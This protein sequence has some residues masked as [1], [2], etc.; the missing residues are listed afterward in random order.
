MKNY[1]EA[2]LDFFR[3]L[4]NSSKKNK[5][6]IINMDDPK[7][8][9]VASII[10]DTVKVIKIGSNAKFDYYIKNFHIKTTVLK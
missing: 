1:F 5:I 4:N 6:A 8:D 10:N 7:G 3:A 9:E 2:K